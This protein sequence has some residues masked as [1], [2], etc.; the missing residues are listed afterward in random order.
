MIIA[1]NFQ[2]KQLERRIPK[3]KTGLLYF[4]LQPQYIYDLFIH[5]VPKFRS[6]HKAIMVITGRA[7]CIHICMIYFI[8][9]TYHFTP[10]ERYELN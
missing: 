1:V 8:Y 2:L 4:H 7:H 6:C 5:P 10:Y 3:K 9:N